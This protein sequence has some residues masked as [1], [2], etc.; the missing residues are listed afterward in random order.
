M[1]GEAAVP[2]GIRQVSLAERPELAGAVWRL[3]AARWP[4]FMLAGRPGHDVD[5]NA[6]LLATARHQIALLGPDGGLLCAG[7]SVPVGWDGS[8]A[9][10][11]AGWDGAVTAAAALHERGGAPGA[12]CALSITREPAAGGRGLGAAMVAALAGAAARVGVGALIAPVR[13][14]LKSRYPLTPMAE[15]AGWLTP[16]GRPFDP[17]LRL[18]LGMGGVPAG[19]AD[20]ALTVTG[21]VA[22]WE[23]WTGLMLPAT[24]DY[25]VPGGLVPLRVD[26]LADSGVYR[27]PNVW[28]VHRTGAAGQETCA[29]SRLPTA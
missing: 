20:P 4:M 10:L 3:L 6:L 24:G 5:L 23:E 15:F 8:P 18:H 7:L 17:W 28:I 12:V 29:P 1:T 2:A 16:D 27:E 9:G 21:T 14:V 13:P 19:I 26:R 11:P 22:Q 25:I